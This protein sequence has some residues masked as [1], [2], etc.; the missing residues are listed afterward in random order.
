MQI[1][2]GHC[3]L[4][5]NEPRRIFVGENLKACVRRILLLMEEVRRPH[6]MYVKLSLHV[7]MMIL[8]LTF[9]AG[10]VPSL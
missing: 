10:Q 4:L 5:L 2:L 7:I 3:V 1:F 6:Q 8:I 9:I